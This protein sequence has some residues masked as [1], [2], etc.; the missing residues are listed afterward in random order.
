M[1]LVQFDYKDFGLASYLIVNGNEFK[2]IDVR[3][4][5][6]FNEVKTYVSVQGDK[7]NL[8]TLQKE[9]ENNKSKIL[10]D[11][12]I[13]NQIEQLRLAVSLIK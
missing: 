2:G 4:I 6:R 9:Y 7:Q 1:E 10:K 13:N 5:K 8:I 3:F 11:E 12:N